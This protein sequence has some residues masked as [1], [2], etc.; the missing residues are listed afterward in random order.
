MVKSDVWK[1]GR[2]LCLP[3]DLQLKLAK[4][5]ISMQEGSFKLTILQVQSLAYLCELVRRNEITGRLNSGKTVT[6]PGLQKQIFSTSKGN[7]VTPETTMRSIFSYRNLSEHDQDEETILHP[8]VCNPSST[9]HHF[10]QLNC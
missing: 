8:T 3:S 10:T 4:P 2:P 1:T 9:S 7:S 6:E 5:A